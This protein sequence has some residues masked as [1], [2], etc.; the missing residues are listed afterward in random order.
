MKIPAFVVVA[1]VV[2]GCGRDAT[3]THPV[4]GDRG[5][6]ITVEVLNANGRA[7]DARVGTRAL[8]RAG[9]D[10]VYFGNAAETGL[11]STLIIVRRGAEQV[12][13]RVRAALGQ[14]R[15]AVQLDSSKLLDVSVL[16]GA[17]FASS[18]RFDF[19]P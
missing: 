15:V 6:A 3:K 16:L 12:G 19:H 10:V 9:I 17:D 5:P 11:D 18:A 8:R 2:G 14:G 1:V 7:G 4:P 13:K